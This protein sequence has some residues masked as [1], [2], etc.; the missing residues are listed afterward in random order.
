LA[1]V[2]QSDD[3]VLANIAVF[4]IGRLGGKTAVPVVQATRDIVAAKAEKDRR[5]DDAV[6]TM[7]LLMARLE[8]K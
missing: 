3:L 8:N 2:L 6:Y 1:G 7:D 4:G 5:L